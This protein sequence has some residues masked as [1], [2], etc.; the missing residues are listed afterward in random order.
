MVN[1]NPKTIIKYVADYYGI[2]IK[3]ITGYSRKQHIFEARLLA[4]ALLRRE[5]K[6]SY[7]SIGEFLNRDHS[8]IVKDL[9][10]NNV[11]INELEYMF[12]KAK[13]LLC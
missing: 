2:S 11:K 10:K 4:M 5:L 1:K 13:R 7:A 3:D 12:Q 9:S 6:M 8:T